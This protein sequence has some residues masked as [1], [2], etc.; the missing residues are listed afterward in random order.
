MASRFDGAA[1][2][3]HFTVHSLVAL[4]LV[5]LLSAG[6][7]K[8]E[9]EAQPNHPAH[10]AAQP[11][12]LALSTAL[13]PLHDEQLQDHGGSPLA[14]KEG[15]SATYVCPMHPEVVR[16]EPGNCPICGMKLVPQKADK[17]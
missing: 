17:K 5:G 15:T 13:P 16:K 1:M 14:A 6:C 7:V 8:S 10:A 2:S 4:G 11:G 9:L 3:T 12:R